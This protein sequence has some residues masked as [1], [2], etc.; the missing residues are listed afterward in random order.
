L[1][2]DPVI[3]GDCE[4]DQ[5]STTATGSLSFWSGLTVGEKIVFPILSV[6]FVGL[7]AA[8]ALSAA[9]GGDP[10]APIL[11][12]ILLLLYWTYRRGK[13]NAGSD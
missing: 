4:R 7:L 6:A 9:N 11:L 2:G 13:S 3:C 12:P 10:E 8:V 5:H 1:G